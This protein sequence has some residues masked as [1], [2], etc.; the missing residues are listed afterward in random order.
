MSAD[1]VYTWLEIAEHVTEESCWIVQEG[2]VFDVTEYLETHPGTK[3]P[4]LKY[5]GIKN[6]K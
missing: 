1:K 2:K 5:A 3:F 6:Q 4:L